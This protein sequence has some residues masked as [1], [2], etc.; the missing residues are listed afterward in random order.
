[1]QRLPKIMTSQT[2]KPID[3]SA[4]LPTLNLRPIIRSWLADD[5]PTFDV[6]GLVVGTAPK[7]AHLYMKSPGVFAGKPFMD[8]VFSELNC[9]VQ[10][11]D[12]HAIEGTF[13][14][15]SK[16]GNEDG[17]DRTLLATVR[18]P[19]NA[20]LRGERTA[21]NTL[22]RCSGVATAAYAA[23]ERVGRECPDWKGAIAGTR[24]VTPGSFR[25]VEKYGLI[26]GGCDT[27]RLDLSQ[28]TMLKDNHIWSCG[29]DIKEAVGLARKAAGFSQ[30]I[31]VECQNLEEAMEAA[32]AGADVVML[33]N[34]SPEVLKSDAYKV[35]QSYPHVLVE[36][37]GGIT[38]ET[39]AD[40][41]CESVDVISRGDL[42]QGY[43]CI[44]YS[45]KIQK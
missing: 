28:M 33:D 2:N 11:N 37:S 9:T 39:M 45:L 25:H 15:P 34:Y 12:K 21:L 26:V 29:G 38:V 6:G 36:A 24:K 16:V 19:A 31:E 35:K 13:I 5:M 41:V 3:Y 40:Y 44:D 43:S 10:W 8:I 17:T 22:S 14:D 20:V 23:N 1:M 42:T 32:G 18:G 27:H 30:K 4:L 7:T